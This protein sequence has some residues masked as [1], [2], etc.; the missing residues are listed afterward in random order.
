MLQFS[1]YYLYVFCR[2]IKIKYSCK[3]NEKKHI[4]TLDISFEM[5]YTSSVVRLDRAIP[6]REEA[7]EQTI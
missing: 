1:S 3:K 2:I 4:F 6:S 7:G 5:R